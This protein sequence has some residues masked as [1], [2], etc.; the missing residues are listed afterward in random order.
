[1]KIF[2]KTHNCLFVEEEEAYKWAA[3]KSGTS[4]HLVT[5]SVLCLFAAFLFGL[6]R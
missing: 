1:M 3:K 4:R 6:L 5:L 2:R